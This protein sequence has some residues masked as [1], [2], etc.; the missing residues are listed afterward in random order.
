MQ[1]STM[2]QEGQP[3]R[4]LRRLKGSSLIRMRNQIFSFLLVRALILFR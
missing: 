4:T 1:I 3:E 2:P